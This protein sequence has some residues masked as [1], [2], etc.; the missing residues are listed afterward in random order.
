M[1]RSEGEPLSG[2]AAGIG[3]STGREAMEEALATDVGLRAVLK[4]RQLQP[5]GR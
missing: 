2:R 1:G 5:F 4:G 3:S